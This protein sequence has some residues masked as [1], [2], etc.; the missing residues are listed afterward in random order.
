MHAKLIVKRF[1][2][3][4]ERQKLFPEVNNLCSQN[5]NMESW[6]QMISRFSLLFLF[7]V[8]LCDTDGEFNVPLIG[9]IGAVIPKH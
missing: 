3:G 1:S 6:Q 7:L 2:L 8:N 9:P 5:S 4:S